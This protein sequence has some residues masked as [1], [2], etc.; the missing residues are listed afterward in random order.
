MGKNEVSEFLCACW[1]VGNLA[2][3]IIL[4]SLEFSWEFFPPNSL[5][6]DTIPQM[7]LLLLLICTEVK[8]TFQ[9]L[10]RNGFIAGAS[11]ASFASWKGS[12]GIGTKRTS[13]HGSI[14]GLGQDSLH[15]P[16]SPGE[17]MWSIYTVRLS[18][19]WQSP[20]PS[21]QTVQ[22]PI[23]MTVSSLFTEQL[24]TP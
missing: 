19:D 20:C 17:G 16:L 8:S 14:K 18:T 12:M 9:F 23:E 24:H 2:V 1:S 21:F 7:K 4:F 6:N 11:L 13:W 5:S 3:R 22:K 10:D 15:P